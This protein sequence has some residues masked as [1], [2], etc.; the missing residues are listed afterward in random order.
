MSQMWRK[1]NSKKCGQLFQDVTSFDIGIWYYVLVID[2]YNDIELYNIIGEKIKKRRKS[3]GITQEKLA[4]LTNYS[5]SFIANIESRTFQTFSISALNTIAKALNTNM[6]SL[7]PKEKELEKIKTTIKCE[8]CGY[9]M[10]LPIEITK[11]IESIN[12]ITHK[13]VRLTCPECHKKIV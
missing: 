12:D 2:M 11:L 8:H 1:I 9:E 5:L 6:L 10:N 13:K 7:L 4:E 3:L